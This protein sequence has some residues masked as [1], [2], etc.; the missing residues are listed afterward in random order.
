MTHRP[1]TPTV[2][3]TTAVDES[4]ST[5]YLWENG[6]LMVFGED[7]QQIPELQGPVSQERVRAI[8][9]RS[10]VRTKWIGFGED[11]RAVWP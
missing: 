6:N 8:Q 9:R 1:R 5:V 10:T 11:G 2:S 4:V 3:G 7:G